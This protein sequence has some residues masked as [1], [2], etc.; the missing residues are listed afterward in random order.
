MLESAQGVNDV[1][2]PAASANMGASH[3]LSVMSLD[4]CSKSSVTAPPN[5]GKNGSHLFLRQAA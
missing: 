2:I 1:K 5:V 3:V 4:N